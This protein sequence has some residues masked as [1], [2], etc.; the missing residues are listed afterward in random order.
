MDKIT[1]INL[2][3]KDFFD[4]NKTVK[5]VP[6][7]NMM[8]YFVLAGIFLKDEK[9]GLPISYLLRKLDANNQLNLIPFVF[10]DRKSV[11]TKWFFQ[12][13]NCSVTQIVK[14]QNKISKKKI[15]DRKK[16]KLNK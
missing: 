7:R 5:K 1:Q 8:P 13:E 9:N 6:A 10:A 3:L 2:V 4:L 14:I 16:K 12:S 15:S 11:Y